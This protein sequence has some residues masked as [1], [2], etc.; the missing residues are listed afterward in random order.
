MRKNKRYSFHFFSILPSNCD[1]INLIPYT[2]V[3][4]VHY[5]CVCVHA[6]CRS[7]LL[8]AYVRAL[9]LSRSVRTSVRLSSFW[10]SVHTC[11]CALLVS[12]SMCTPD[13]PS[14]LFSL[15]HSPYFCLRFSFFSSFY[16][17]FLSPVQIIPCQIMFDIKNGSLTSK[18]L[19]QRYHLTNWNVVTR[20]RLKYS[21]IHWITKNFVLV[22]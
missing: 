5:H 11:A 8:S 9:C 15:F 1:R 20:Y 18:T 17:F 16:L 4:L 14:L 22:C 7:L 10:F 6:P 3:R 12:T 2:W 21:N 13:S 19:F